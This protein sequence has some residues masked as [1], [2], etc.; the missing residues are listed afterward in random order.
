VQYS[1]AQN[2]TEQCSASQCSTLHSRATRMAQPSVDNGP[3]WMGAPPL[4]SIIT[5]EASSACS[6]RGGLAAA[7]RLAGA[8]ATAAAA[9]AA[10][11]PS[12]SGASSPSLSAPGP[13]GMALSSATSTPSPC[14]SPSPEPWTGTGS[15]S[16]A[17]TLPRLGQGEGA[18]PGQGRPRALRR[19]PAGCL[20]QGCP[21]HFP[22]R[23]PPSPPGT[24]Q[25]PRQRPAAPGWTGVRPREPASPAAG[26]RGSAHRGPAANQTQ[27]W[28]ATARW[29][30][31][32][33]RSA[34]GVP[35]VPVHQQEH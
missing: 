27:R 33:C 12:R 2:S 17:G 8:V 34:A 25:L 35:L 1:T 18:H 4:T 28:R 3:L 31:R 26:P 6:T 11:A 19:L 32:G 30:P 14:L 9:A 22:Q 21:V 20:P 16:G 5:K 29:C 10:A 15:G 23:R 7:G 13:G 24:W